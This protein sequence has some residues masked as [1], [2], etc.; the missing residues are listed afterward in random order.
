M[1]REWLSIN[2]LAAATGIPESTT[3]RYIRSFGRYLSPT[4]AKGKF[5][6]YAASA[7]PILEQISDWYKSGREREEIETL[8]RETQP[9]TVEEV[10]L[11]TTTNPTPSLTVVLE[12][13]AASLE[14]LEQTVD[15]TR[16]I[17]ALEQTR[18]ALPLWF[19]WTRKKPTETDDS[20]NG[21]K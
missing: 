12:R 11:S 3:R 6:R 16:R 21:Q 18:K 13:I 5:R 4:K 17:E 20:H 7:V 9:L 14:R 10:E 8:L 19:R 2:G 15:L 1:N